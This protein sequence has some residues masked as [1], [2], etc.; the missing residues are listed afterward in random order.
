[1]NIYFYRLLYGIWFQKM[2]R[3]NIISNTQVNEQLT[4]ITRIHLNI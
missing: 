4:A 2:T 1:M 3:Y